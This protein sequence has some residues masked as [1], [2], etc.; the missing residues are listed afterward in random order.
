MTGVSESGSVNAVFSEQSTHGQFAEREFKSELV[1]VAETDQHAEEDPLGT[2]QLLH[3][4]GLAL[5][6]GLQPGPVRA[7]VSSYI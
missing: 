3:C 5:A 6:L 7:S 4:L 1:I 2:Q